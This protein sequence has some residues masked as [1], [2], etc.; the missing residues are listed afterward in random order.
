MPL[1]S[2]LV[3]IWIQS[4]CICPCLSRRWHSGSHLDCLKRAEELSSRLA[5][6]AARN[7]GASQFVHPSDITTAS[8]QNFT[9]RQNSA[10]GYSSTVT[11]RI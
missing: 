5:Q 10:E 7:D 11:A 4:Q 3:R 2:E 6:V 1:K 8:I 9:W